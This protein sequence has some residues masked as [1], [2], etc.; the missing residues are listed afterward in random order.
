MCFW[1]K[2]EKEIEMDKEK[3]DEIKERI[4]VRIIQKFSHGSVNLQA[5]RF[6]TSDVIDKRK[7]ALGK[8]KFSVSR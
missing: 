5:G 1:S 4:I 3:N 2:G 8:H 7:V 6:L